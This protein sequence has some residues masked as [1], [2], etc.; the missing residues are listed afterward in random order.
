MSNAPPKSFSLLLYVGRW[1]KPASAGG[2]WVQPT[3][4][5]VKGCNPKFGSFPITHIIK[6]NVSGYD[7]RKLS[8]DKYYKT[9]A[10]LEALKCVCV[11]GRCLLMFRLYFPWSWYTSVRAGDNE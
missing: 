1:E 6:A 4:P 3:G 11:Q 2:G 10:G 8:R 9:D 7:L 5:R